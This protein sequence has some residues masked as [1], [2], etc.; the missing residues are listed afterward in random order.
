MKREKTTTTST[1]AK[2]ERAAKVDTQCV[3]EKHT[4]G[5]CGGSCA[6]HTPKRVIAYRDERFLFGFVSGLAV[7]AIAGFIIVT[8][9]GIVGGERT[10]TAPRAAQVTTTQVA[11]GDW[12]YGNPR[13]KV[14]IIEYSDIDCPYC[15]KFHKTLK[16]VVDASNGKVRW[17]YRHAPID[18]L[19][20]NARLKAYIAECIGVQRGNEAF[21]AALD[22]LMKDGAIATQAD[23]DAF[24]ADTGVNRKQFDACVTDGTYVAKVKRQKRDAQQLGLKGTPFSVI[25]AG[26]KSV[27]VPGAVSRDRME[28]LLAPFVR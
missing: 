12:I 10:A 11:K 1:S 25:V 27:P 26:R 16:D 20:P 13:A 5:C 8:N 18:S 15:K 19:H 3:H 14:A 28:K 23:F 4:T 22:S 6:I 2:K 17:I 21:W 9:G 7:A 24:V